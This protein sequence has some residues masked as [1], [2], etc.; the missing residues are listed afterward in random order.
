[1][2]IGKKIKANKQQTNK[3]TKHS[4]VIFSLPKGTLAVLQRFLQDRQLDVFDGRKF[5]PFSQYEL[6]PKEIRE[7]E[8][9]KIFP[10][11][12]SFRVIAVGL[13]YCMKSKKK[14][15]KLKQTIEISSMFNIHVTHKNKKKYKHK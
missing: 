15:N 5:L 14:R 9:E 6:I 12:P 7:K 1:M 4:H 13:P 8:R 3:Q 11:H 10:I 2:L